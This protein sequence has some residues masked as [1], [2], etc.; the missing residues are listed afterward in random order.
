MTINSATRKAGPFLG[1]GVTTVFP[2]TFKVFTKNDV[3][4]TLTSS[5]GA[6]TQLALDSNYTVAV[7]GDQTVSPGGTVTYPATLATGYKLTITGALPNLQPTSL[8]NNGPF[9]PK[10]IEDAEDRAIILIQQLQEKVD[11]SI[12]VNVSDTPLAPLPTAGSRANSVLG[13]DAIGG[14][15]TLPLPASVGAGDMRVDT[16]V[17]GVDF[18]AGVTTSLNL[19]RA[20]GNPANL[21][22]FFDG[23]FQGPDQ[24]SLSGA[25]VTFTSAIPAGI[26]KVFARSGTTLSTQIP[27]TKSVGDSQLIWGT[28]LGK[29]V[30]TRAELK[31][32]D[33][34]TY[35]RAFVLGYSAAGD[36]GGL[37]PVYF[38]S[39]SA[40]ADNGG[41]I[42]TPNVGSG[43]WLMMNTSRLNPFMFGAKG[44]KVTDDTAAIQ[45]CYNAVPIGGTFRLPVAPGLAY[46]V[47]T[48]PGGYCLDFSRFVHIEAEGFFSALQ[49]AAGTTSNTVRLK[50]VVGGGYWGMKWEGLTLGDPFTGTRAGLNGI[51]IDTQVDGSQL[52]AGIFRNLN[53][54]TGSVVGGVGILHINSS[55]G[56]NINGGMYGTSFEDCIVK[57]GFNLQ[58]SGDSNVIK[59]A[60]ISGPNV[61]VYFSLTAGASLLTLEDC[62]ITSTGGA[63]LA[64]SGSRFKMYHCNCEQIQPFTQSITGFTT[65]CMVNVRGSNGTMSTPEI[66]GNHFGLFS[67]VP[68][69]AVVRINNVIGGKADGNVLLNSNSAPTGFIVSNSTN[70]RIGDGNTYGTA[71]VT[72]GAKVSD[73]GTGTMGVYKPLASTLINAWSQSPVSPTATFVSFKTCAGEVIVDG[74]L[75]GG[76]V[77]SGTAFAMLPAGHAPLET[78]EFPVVTYNGATLVPGHVRIETDGTMRIMSGQNTAMYLSGIRFMAAD[79]ADATSDL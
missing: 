37:G 34:T 55:V 17:G 5:S 32:L 73:T 43:N 15:T 68:N 33:T 21:E 70:F 60:L 18:T 9:Y 3:Q 30:S 51:F 41:S 4:V 75:S 1:D 19:S 36:L 8:P 12:K 61:G 69:S 20:P 57:G 74:K 59:R 48:Q 16:F 64:D 58:G 45:A 65:D 62:N 77:T 27:P 22:I 2:F 49:P 31:A 14:V 54:M 39:T 28:S 52:P 29:V 67:G 42:T 40:L 78:R 26:S 35:Q 63:V 44:D 72:T 11:R 7:N 46:I 66:V 71:I 38:S 47:S 50:P 13:F 56:A 6:E 25:V 23:A 24:W 76:T 79:L 10:T 53:V